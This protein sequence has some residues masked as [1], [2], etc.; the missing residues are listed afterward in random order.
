MVGIE[1]AGFGT[2][3]DVQQA[4]VVVI[5]DAVV[6]LQ[7]ESA[8][9]CA[10]VQQLRT[11][12]QR[13]RHLVMQQRSQ[14]GEVVGQLGQGRLQR[15]AGT[16]PRQLGPL[17][18][19]LHPR[20]QGGQWRTSGAGRSRMHQIRHRSKPLQRLQLGQQRLQPHGRPFQRAFQRSVRLGL[21]RCC[22][23]AG[24]RHHQQVAGA[25]AAVHRRDIA[26]RQHS[27]RA[28]VIPVVEMACVARHALQRRQGGPQP[29]HQIRTA[30][31]ADLARAGQH[32]QVHADVG[33]RRAVRHHLE[34][35]HLHVVR[36]QEVV[37]LAHM[38]VIEAPGVMRQLEQVAALLLGDAFAARPR[39]QAA[40]HRHPHRHQR[41]QQQQGQQ[42]QPVHRPACQMRAHGSH[43][44][45][46]CHQ[47][48]G[49]VLAQ[50]RRQVGAHR[51]L[52]GCRRHPFQQQ[53]A[54][55]QLPVQRAQHGI[56]IQHGLIQQRG[57]MPQRRHQRPAQILEAFRKEVA[58]GNVVAVW[59][60]AG[61][62]AE[63]R[64]A[65]IGRQHSD[66]GPV[67]RQ[68]LRECHPQQQQRRER[69]HHGTAQVVRHLPVVDQRHALAPEQ[70]DQRQQ[71]PV[72]A[73]PAVQT[74]C[75]H[76]GMH[77]RVLDKGHVA[78]AGAAQQGTFQ[79][80]M[81]QHM[82]RRQLAAQHRVRGLHVE[83]A[84]AGEGALPE[85]VLVDL[86]TG[87]AVRIHPE[88]A[89]K[90]AVEPGAGFGRRHRRGNARLQDAVTTTDETRARLDA[91][92][93]QRMRGNRHQFAQAARRHVGIAVQRDE[94]AHA[95]RH[96]REFAQIDE[97][98]RQGFGR[99]GQRLHQLLQLAALTFPADVALLRIAPFARAMQHQKAQ[100]AP[101][102]HRIA[103]VQLGDT[104]TGKGQ[105]SIIA[106][107]RLRGGIGKIGQQGKLR[108][109]L[110]VGQ[111]VLLQ[112]DQQLTCALL[113]GQ[114]AG[115]HHQRL[116]RLRNALAQG[117]AVQH[118]WL[119][120]LADQAVDQRHHG[121]AQRRQQQVGRHGP[122]P[123]MDIRPLVAQIHHT[124]RQP[125]RDQHH[126][127]QIGPGIPAPSHRAGTCRETPRRQAEGL[128][129]LRF[130]LAAPPVGRCH[131][132]VIRPFAL[133]RQ[134]HQRLRHLGLR[135]ARLARKPLDGMQG[136]VLRGQ[137]LRHVLRAGRH[138]AHDGV[139]AGKQLAPVHL[140]DLAQ[141]GDR[142][143][144]A[145][146]VLGQRG[147]MARFGRRRILQPHLEPG[148]QL[149]AVVVR[150]V[151][152]ALLHLQ[153]KGFFHAEAAEALFQLVE[154][155]DGALLLRAI[156]PAVGRITRRLQCR[157]AQRQP[158]QVFQQHHAQRGRK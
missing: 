120:R 35:L 26:R 138:D 46:A 157:R 50:Q 121:F 106:L 3:A 114:H 153:Q 96:A 71:L 19:R 25:V 40:D 85:H 82:L 78:H 76:V 5:Q 18:R 104:G 72:A 158:R 103:L 81:A 123:A 148:M 108:M 146:L 47:H 70:A 80:V 115:N 116:V 4:A 56:A 53:P 12:L 149:P 67:E 54:R 75:G 137:A 102:L 73:R 94:V 30:D 107:H 42:R 143:A 90:Q 44:Q 61:Q 145:L 41:P 68:R 65:A 119:H 34:G 117:H 100:R 127:Q 141:R 55:Y 126:R 113:A 136:A 15:R 63:Q 129:Q 58:Q 89:G 86:G 21:Q 144:D 140:V 29:R 38:P 13:L 110:G 62:R 87:R 8:A 6:R 11:Q 154:L 33:R 99:F 27:Q 88:A 17:A 69:R 52:R 66:Q 118:R 37:F 14:D 150:E 128:A 95:R 124:Q 92:L 57:Q 77:G 60:E 7:C 31:E 133:R 105:R 151:F 32:Q 59:R 84:L 109:R 1:L 51:G 10:Q 16:L 45:H 20:Q 135:P 125:A 131:Q 111:M 91:R 43:Q 74:R 9:A 122:D 139:V 64:A 49:L 132:R 130:A 24:T 36:R 155:A 98:S 147:L 48:G 22:L 142:V 39:T 23:F 93:V 79:Q 134:V 2:Q 97:R 28:R 156:E 152:L 101:R 83:Q 112:L